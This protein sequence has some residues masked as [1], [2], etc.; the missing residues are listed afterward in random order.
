VTPLGD[1]I[2]RRRTVAFAEAPL[3]AMKEAGKAIDDGVTVN[4]VVLAIVAGGVGRWLA[5]VQGP[6]D[7]IRAKVP[8]S[9]HHIGDALANHDSYF[10]VDL[11]VAE[12]D[13]AKRVITINRETRERKLDHDAETLYWL[14]HHSIVSRWAMSPHVFTFN[15]SNVCGPAGE[16]YVLGARVSG[17]Y[18]LAEIGRHHALRV[19]VISSGGSLFFGLCADAD[20]VDDLDV[21]AD[22][23]SAAID[24]LLAL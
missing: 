16:I 10:F 3:G 13:V 24:A 1:R 19:S 7:G 21:L 2:G 8:V 18:S 11:P 9:L 22:G 20:A 6:M 15:V 5:Q 17:M 23:I 4:D 12:P 14:G